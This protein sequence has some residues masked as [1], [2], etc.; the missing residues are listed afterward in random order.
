MQAIRFQSQRI[1]SNANSLLFLSGLQIKSLIR[2]KDLK[3]EEF[4]SLL[5]E[6]IEKTDDFLRSYV[7][8]KPEF[9][10]DYA[11]AL[12][13]GIANGDGMGA[14][15]GFAISVKDIFNTYNFPTQMGS[16]LLNNFT[17]GN[18]ARVVSNLRLDDAL[19]TGKVSTAEFAVHTPP[20]TINPFDSNRS[21]GTSST[22][23]AVSV[24]A[25]MC[26]G[27]ICSQTAGSI[28]RPASYNGVIGFKPTYGL[29]PRTGVL[30]TTDTLDSVG[31]M[32]NYLE[33]IEA[34]FEA[35]RL[36]GH[37]YP[38]LNGKVEKFSKKPLHRKWKVGVVNGPETKCQNPFVISSL[39]KLLSRLPTSEFSLSEANLSGVFYDAHHV[40]HTLYAKCL[41]YYFRPEFEKSKGSLSPSFRELCE[42]GSKISAEKYAEALDMQNKISESLDK[43]LNDYDFLIDLSAADEA[44][45]QTSSEPSDHA[46]IYT[47]S[48]VPAIS[49]PMLAGTNNLPVGVQVIGPRFSDTKLLQFSRYLMENFVEN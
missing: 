13:R 39:Q 4:V 18:D 28:I 43:I 8:F 19:I 25:L 1:K 10:V 2:N 47:M 34:M 14:L 49:L 37:N 35:T 32:A 12:D 40:H 16:K 15:S 31:L 44:P 33:D 20:D 5:I 21:P 48:R 42:L 11:K 46:L 38:V 24:A 36:Q 3:S 9:L 30:K 23:S 45:H 17:P 27:S 26:H 41:S 6:H 22:G 29:L 7:S